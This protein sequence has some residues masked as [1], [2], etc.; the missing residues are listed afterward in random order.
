MSLV[1]PTE[2]L[3]SFSALHFLMQLVSYVQKARNKFN[4]LR[5]MSSL[6]LLDSK[7]GRA[8]ET[9]LGYFGYFYKE[10]CTSTCPHGAAGLTYGLSSQRPHAASFILG[11]EV[12]EWSLPDSGPVIPKWTE[13]KIVVQSIK[14]SLLAEG[15]HLSIS[16]FRQ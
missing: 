7:S 6:S 14:Q 1:C 12:L 3:T 16:L 13:S 2:A 5:Q 10:C 4:L 8:L 9:A 15:V 11:G